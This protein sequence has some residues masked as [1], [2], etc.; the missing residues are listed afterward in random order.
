MDGPFS[1]PL[2]CPSPLGCR[3]C[4]WLWR[5]S[6]ERASVPPELEEG[7]GELSEVSGLERGDV[8]VAQRTGVRRSP[9]GPGVTSPDQ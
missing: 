4:G 5:K 8:G 2:L 9:S 1:D 6:W 3:W 7:Q